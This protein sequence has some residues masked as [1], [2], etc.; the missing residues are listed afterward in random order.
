MLA[1]AG[2]A[3]NAVATIAAP[4]AVI[5][6]APAMIDATV[7]RGLVI[8]ST[9][10]TVVPSVWGI[11]ASKARQRGWTDGVSQVNAW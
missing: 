11:S 1:V 4:R 2:M 10:S 8:S 7:D 6:Q 5:A 9:P 3:V